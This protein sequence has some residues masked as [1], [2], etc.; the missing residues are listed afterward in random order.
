MSSV[1]AAPAPVTSANYAQE[2]F[3]N[4][5]SISSDQFFG[6]QSSAPADTSAQSSARFAGAT[7]ISSAQYYNRDESAMAARRMQ[8]Q[9]EFDFEDLLGGVDVEAAKEKV[10]E[11]GSKL[12]NMAKDW[13]DDWG[14]F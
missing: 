9:D 4:S 3:A 14:G 11:V 12:S 6:R 13:M 5:S 8:S 7:S 1:S 10:L 2:K